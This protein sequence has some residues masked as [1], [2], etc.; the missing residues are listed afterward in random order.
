MAALSAVV[1]TLSWWL[2]L[3]LLARDPRK[4][5]LVLG[6]TGLTSFAAVVALDAVRVVN[7]SELLSRVEIYLVAIPGVAWFV[8]LVELSRPCERWRSRAGEF[9]AVAVVATLSLVGAVLAGGVNGPLRLGHWVMFGTVSV[10]TLV[11]MV[12]AVRRQTRLSAASRRGP[13]RRPSPPSGRR[14]ATGSP[15]TTLP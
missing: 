1:F 5:I 2:G 13:R 15:A 7:G 12:L 11:A 8:V 3:Y 14:R 6:A 9:L 10:S 4:P